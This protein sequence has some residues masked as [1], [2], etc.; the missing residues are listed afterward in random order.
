M[1]IEQEGQELLKVH[2]YLR[3]Q[4]IEIPDKREMEYQEEKEDGER[5]GKPRFKQSQYD[6]SEELLT[7]LRDHLQDI[8]NFFNQY[9]YWFDNT[10][11]PLIAS[12]ER[13]MSKKSII[14]LLE[15]DVWSTDEVYGKYLIEK[16][17]DGMVIS[18]FRRAQKIRQYK[19]PTMNDTEV[20][21]WICNNAVNQIKSQFDF[22]WNKLETEINACIEEIYHR[23]PKLTITS[24]YLQTQLQK[25]KNISKEWP[26]A[27]LLSLGRIIELWL[28]ISLGRKKKGYSPFSDI[29]R[30]AELVGLVGKYEG[31]LLR[32]IWRI[33]NNLKHKTYYK[34]EKQL[35]IDLIEEFSSSLIN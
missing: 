23:K 2:S 6:W 28:L 3:E 1:T 30:D 10:I 22:L 8:W 9:S 17:R 34:V 12:E 4:L 21:S 33:Y 15:N 19:L 20:K 5:I 11:I 29:I 31:K 26:E 32:K 16:R 7:N 25:T 18:Y 24:G 27:A 13:R 35:V 14:F